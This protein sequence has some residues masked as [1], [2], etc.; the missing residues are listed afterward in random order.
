MYRPTHERLWYI[1]ASFALVVL[2]LTGCSHKASE[3]ASAANSAPVKVE[4]AADSSV[5]EANPEQ[6][7]LV[8]VETRNVANQVVTNGSVTWDVTRSVPIASIAGGR[9]LD[10]KARLGDDVKV[11]QVLL[12]IDSPD[13]AG[14]QADYRRAVSSE[15]LTE[16]SYERV[17]A[18]YEHKAAPLKDVQQAEEDLQRARVDKQAASERIRI[19]GTTPDSPSPIIYVKSPVTG[20]V[21]EQNTTR[22]AAIKSLDN[23]PNLFTIADLSRVW[24]LC[25]LYENNLA[26]V[27]IGDRAEVTLSAYPDRRLTARVGN[28]SRVLDP[29]TRTAKVRLELNNPDGI[30]RPGMFATARFTSRME[31]ARSVVPMSAII[32]MHDKSWV[33]RWEG[34]HRFRRTEVQ[35][36]PSLSDGMQE[37]RSGLQPTD[38]V[39]GNAL[40]FASATDRKE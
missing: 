38:Q 39:I 5:L 22:G 26:D 23:S 4:S 9:V 15:R 16:K 29:A 12:V 32:R 19:I 24:I 21:V 11:G 33:F 34:S 17:K 28:I 14:A 10:I 2:S 13:L 40:Q 36:G 3:Q 7:P 35:T 25:D 18:L 1:L 20:T 30:L 31:Q 27:R 6:Y 37:I 8:K